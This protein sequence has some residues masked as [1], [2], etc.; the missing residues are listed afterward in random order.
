MANIKIG[1]LTIDKRF[2][3][4]AIAAATT[5]GDTLQLEVR[6]DYIN[7]SP[8]LVNYDDLTSSYKKALTDTLDLATFQVE[9]PAV[10]FKVALNSNTHTMSGYDRT[11]I[12]STGVDIDN[13]TSLIAVFTIAWLNALDNRLQLGLT[14]KD[15]V[16]LDSTEVSDLAA[17]GITVSGTGDSFT[18][19]A[20]T[21]YQLQCVRPPLET[22]VY[23]VDHDYDI[24]LIRS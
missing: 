8:I 11:S 23:V 18:I 3:Q 4:D 12:K 20:A 9:D 21:P 19:N 15:G 24:N 17:K 2:D 22:A 7:A 13:A 5:A 6:N 10:V 1:T 14:L 16:A